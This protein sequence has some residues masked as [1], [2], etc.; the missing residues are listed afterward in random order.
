[1]SRDD[2]SKSSG[3]LPKWLVTLI[4]GL[5]TGLIVVAA[6]AGGS[7]FTGHLQAKSAA[8]EQG[9]GAARAYLVLFERMQGGLD[10][11]VKYKQQIAPPIQK[12][13]W[14]IGIGDL[15][16]LG[17]VLSPQALYAVESASQELDEI[18]PKRFHGEPQQSKRAHRAY[19]RHVGDMVQA[20]NQVKCAV[21]YLNMVHGVMKKTA[22]WVTGKGA[23]GEL[24]KCETYLGGK[25]SPAA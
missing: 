13:K 12:Y 23:A 24:A 5:I 1:M 15:E 9:D 2:G 19:A 16:A 14:N 4:T 3:K 6:G 22:A 11:D 17:V 8:V 10:S 7:Y 21:I 20:A 18:Y 25:P